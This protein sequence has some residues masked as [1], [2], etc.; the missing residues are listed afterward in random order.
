[1]PA[2]ELGAFTPVLQ[3]LFDVVRADLEDVD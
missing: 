1:L 3:E 2:Q